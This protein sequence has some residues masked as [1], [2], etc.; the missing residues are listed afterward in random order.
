MYTFLFYLPFL[1]FFVLVAVYGERKI[2]AFI[3]SRFG[4]MDVGPKGMF[5]TLADLLKMIQKE[6]IVPKAADKPIFLLG[7]I[8]VFTAI[9]AG[10]SMLPL[11]ANIAGAAVESGVLLLMAVVSLDVLGI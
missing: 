4:P 11:N 1:L 6:D 5:Q 10:F 8:L 2:A 3:Q 9:F 7:P